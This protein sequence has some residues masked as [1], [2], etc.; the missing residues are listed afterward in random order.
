MFVLIKI[1]AISILLFA[2]LFHCK[3]ISQNGLLDD[4]II[5]G[6]L[7]FAQTVSKME[8]FSFGFHNCDSL[9]ICIQISKLCRHGHRNIYKVYPNDP[10]KT[11]EHWPGGYAQLTKV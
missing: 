3:Q 6:Q 7:I 4:I 2:Q 1:A 9:S 11:E 10:W 8:Q 5:D